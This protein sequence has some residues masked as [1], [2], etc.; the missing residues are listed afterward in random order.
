M[1]RR[2][3]GI[4]TQPHG[5]YSATYGRGADTSRSIFSLRTGL[6]P[7]CAGTFQAFLTRTPGA[8]TSPESGNAVST[9]AKILSS[10]KRKMWSNTYLLR[11]FVVVPFPDNPFDFNTFCTVSPRATLDRKSTRLNSSHITI[12]YAVFC[13]KKKKKKK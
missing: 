12:S 11:L 4:R 7:V 13:L 5:R 1:P 8:C 9:D 10:E 2:R 3:L 6:F